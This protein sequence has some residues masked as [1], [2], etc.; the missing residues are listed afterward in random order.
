MKSTAKTISLCYQLLPVIGIVLGKV[1][2]YCND[3][4]VFYRGKTMPCLYT[5]DMYSYASY[6]EPPLLAKKTSGA[7]KMKRVL[8][9]QLSKFVR[10][11]VGPLR[12][13]L[14]LFLFGD[15][16]Y[17]VFFVNK[18]NL[19][20]RALFLMAIA[21][22]VAQVKGMGDM[23]VWVWINFIHSKSDK[24]EKMKKKKEKQEKRELAKEQARLNT[25]RAGMI[26]RAQV[27]ISGTISASLTIFSVFN[28]GALDSIIVWSVVYTVFGVVFIYFLVLV[29]VAGHKIGKLTQ[30]DVTNFRTFL[31]LC[32]V[33]WIT[34]M[35]L[36]YGVRCITLVFLFSLSILIVA[37]MTH[38][39]GQVDKLPKTMKKYL[40]GFV[41]S[42]IISFA[43][44][45]IGFFLKYRPNPSDC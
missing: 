40:P 41:A 39:E 38:I 19:E 36:D 29:T 17:F 45:F 43:A 10:T 30:R 34:S 5:Q 24:A 14:N 13:I 33:I 23:A 20:D 4:P 16:L 32:V 2:E 9:M 21:F 3:P 37:D 25:E 44:G 6:P 1:T 11:I 7:K 15:I 42:P 22:I 27:F 31:H 12:A 26:V 28:D 8:Q 18:A 35:S